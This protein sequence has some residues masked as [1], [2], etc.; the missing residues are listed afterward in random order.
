MYVKYKNLPTPNNQQQTYQTEEAVVPRKRV[1]KNIQS[2]IRQFKD[3]Y[4]Y[5]IDPIVFT[6]NK[7]YSLIDPIIEKF[8][9]ADTKI[10]EKKF[11]EL[12][13]IIIILMVVL[14]ICM[15]SIL[16]IIK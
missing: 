2:R 15:F 10:L 4:T 16:L 1:P 8:D 5:E 9:D 13:K 12:Y 14:F 11:N 3:M 7:D 6:N